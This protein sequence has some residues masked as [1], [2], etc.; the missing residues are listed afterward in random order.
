VILLALCATPLRAADDDARDDQAADKKKGKGP[1]EFESL[2]YRLV[3]PAVGGRVARVSGV[4]GNPLVYYAATASG[5]VWKSEDGGITWKSIFDD[6]PISSI[7]SI[8]VSPSNP[9]VIYVG[10]GEANIRGNVAAGNGIYKS[11]DAGKTWQHV[12]V[13][14]GQIG[15]M[16]VHPT[17]PDIAF[18]AVLGHAFGP[19]PERGVY[20][21]KDGGKTWQQVLKK[22]NDT[23]A[24]D[25][26]IDPGN[27]S[28]V[29]AG[30]WQ[31]RRTP[32]GLTSAGP[33]SGLY[34]S[35]DGGDTWKQLKS[36][37]AGLPEGMWGK[38]GCAVAPSD[39]RRVYA[40]IE[41]E[42]GGLFR[43][44]DGGDS[45]SLASDHHALR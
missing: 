24:S 11:N 36:G 18:A 21:T 27:P 35:H 10:S 3:G 8:V 7:G 14:E 38:V 15:T 26:C 20:R 45:W 40:L 44:D 23:G 25:V 12:W 9:N 30:F 2:K 4:V 19:N 1:A 29:F 22:D 39:G 33:G 42:K 13:Q 5:G 34:A 16:A 31:A 32:W 6:Q 28:I 17:N 37:S 43:S 41:A